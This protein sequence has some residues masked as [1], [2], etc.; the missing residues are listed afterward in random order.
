MGKIILEAGDAIDLAKKL[1]GLPD[2]EIEGGKELVDNFLNRIET[3]ERFNKSVSRMR[4]GMR[5]GMEVDGVEVDEETLTWICVMLEKS[6][7][8]E[9]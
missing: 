3:V 6:E 2:L 4:F 5:M 8:K 7:G 1:N 9:W